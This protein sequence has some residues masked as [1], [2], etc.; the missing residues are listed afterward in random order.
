MTDEQLAIIEEIV[1]YESG[2]SAHGCLE[3]LDSYALKAIE[4]YGRLLLKKQK[5]LND[6]QN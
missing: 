1:F 3:K 2:L 5:E 4:K 6:Q